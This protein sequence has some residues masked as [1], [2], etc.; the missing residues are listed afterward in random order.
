MNSGHAIA[1]D[2]AKKKFS[3]PSIRAAKAGARR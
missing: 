2:Y 3:G 1:I